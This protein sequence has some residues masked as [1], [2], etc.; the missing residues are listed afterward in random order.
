MPDTLR[1]RKRESENESE[2]EKR[3]IDTFVKAHMPFQPTV[4][5]LCT[6]Y[7][8]LLIHPGKN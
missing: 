5:H 3:A 7:L 4:L 8:Y 1:K 6:M 2:K